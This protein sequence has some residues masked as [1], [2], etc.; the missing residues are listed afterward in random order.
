MK[1][2]QFLLASAAFA[3]LAIVTVSQST[4]FAG[5]YSSSA[6]YRAPSA[7]PVYGF[8]SNGQSFTYHPSGSAYSYSTRGGPTG[9]GVYGPQ[10]RFDTF[11]SPRNAPSY[12]TPIDNQPYFFSGRMW[13][14]RPF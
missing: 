13:Y 3:G 5:R 6:A 12:K 8:R 4:C 10:Y 11:T 2:K 7:S 1:T 14:P 9:S